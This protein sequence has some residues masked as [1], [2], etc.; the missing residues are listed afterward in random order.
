MKNINVICG[1]LALLL[2]VAAISSCGKPADSSQNSGNNQGTDPDPTPSGPYF[3]ATLPDEVVLNMD[4]GAVS[5]VVDTNIEDWTAT[6]SESWCKPV[7]GSTELLLQ[8]EAYDARDDNGQYQYDPPR[9][10]TVDVTAGT[11]FSKSIRIVQQ[12]YTIITFPQQSLS[13]N[14]DWIQ[15]GPTGMII[16]LSSDGDTREVMISSNAWLWVPE[17]TALWLKAEYVDGA[18]LK[19]TSSARA[20]SETSARSAQVKVYDKNNELVYSTFTVQDAPANVE[21]Q[22]FGYG[23]HTGWD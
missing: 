17:T 5:W 20:Q 18:T 21:G 9:T 1:I 6:S 7:T 16:L 3:T 15:D 2:C 13:A 22:D 11:V 4:P 19:L 23:D 8:I 14:Y 12:T 10:C